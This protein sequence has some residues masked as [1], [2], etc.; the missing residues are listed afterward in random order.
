MQDQILVSVKRQDQIKQVIPYLDKIAE[1]GMRVVFLVR[2]SASIWQWM[3]GHLTAM[4]TG[5]RIALQNC[6]IARRYDVER[7]QRLAEEFVARSSQGLR[8]RGVET[9][10]QIH[11]GGLK[12]VL[13]HSSRARNVR[14]V[15]VPASD[16]FGL[17][18]LGRLIRN[19]FTLMKRPGSS[20]VVLLHPHNTAER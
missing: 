8:H 15:M 6:Q 11:S 2:S 1:P 9:E 17:I 7:Q 13:E 12:S 14:L 3:N 20:R 18:R 4:H 16:A 10:V 5:N 19:T